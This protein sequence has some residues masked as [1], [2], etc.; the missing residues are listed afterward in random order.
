M[1]HEEQNKQE[2]GCMCVRVCV[3]GGGLKLMAPA[4]QKGVICQLAQCVK[5]FF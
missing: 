1:E 5:V 2:E 4:L 3:W